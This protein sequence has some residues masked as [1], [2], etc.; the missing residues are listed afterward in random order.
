M[1]H[2]KLPEEAL[3]RS[4]GS[5]S[6]IPS[7]RW[8]RPGSPEIKLPGSPLV[9]AAQQVAALRQNSQRSDAVLFRQM[10]LGA[11]ARGA[12]SIIASQGQLLASPLPTRRIL[13]VQTANFSNPESSAASGVPRRSSVQQQGRHA[14]PCS[15]ARVRSPMREE[16][17]PETAKRFD[18]MEKELA[19]ENAK[20]FDAMEKDVA[21]L[22]KEVRAIMPALRKEMLML[23]SENLSHSVQEAVAQ[24]DLLQDCDMR[25]CQ[26][27]HLAQ[28]EAQL[29]EEA[30][31]KQA[32][33]QA[34][35]RET[36]Q[37]QLEQYCLGLHQA[38]SE[39]RC[40]MDVHLQTQLDALRKECEELVSLWPRISMSALPERVDEEHLARLEEALE[41]ETAAR[42]EADAT[43]LAS[44][45]ELVHEEERRL[46]EVHYQ[47]E[48]RLQLHW[49]DLDTREEMKGDEEVMTPISARLRQNS[50]PILLG[51]GMVG[52]RGVEKPMAVAQPPVGDGDAS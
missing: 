42:K 4:V 51:M 14:P 25:L 30:F 37:I 40:G 13:H 44:A 32:A 7:A 22:W 15:S 39:S 28:N 24:N 29:R 12:T 18:A 33:H 31:V 8:A 1:P 46:L 2:P 10:S 16:L 50:G 6:P 11:V 27:E 47:L 3:R 5:V 26:L 9:A 20:R 21:F 35:Q 34:G 19:F 36:F 38:E 52:R 23:I 43:L 49:P 17:A 45:R 41:R 48:R